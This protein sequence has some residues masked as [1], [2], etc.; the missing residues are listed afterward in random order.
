[1]CLVTGGLLLVS[2]CPQFYKQREVTIFLTFCY[3]N[4]DFYL[5]RLLKLLILRL[6]QISVDSFRSV[7]KFIS[8][9]W[10]ASFDA[11]DFVLTFAV[12]LTRSIS[13]ATNTYIIKPIW[14]FSNHGALVIW[15]SPYISFAASCFAISFAFFCHANNL[16]LWVKL[17]SIVEF[18]QSKVALHV[19]PRGFDMLLRIEWENWYHY[20]V[21]SCSNGIFASKSIVANGFPTENIWLI[22]VNQSLF[23]LS[24]LPSLGWTLY[25]VHLGGGAS[26]RALGGE[27]KVFIRGIMKAI[28]YPLIFSFVL[29]TVPFFRHFQCLTFSFGKFYTTYTVVSA[30][31]MMLEMNRLRNAPDVSV[32]NASRHRRHPYRQPYFANVATNALIENNRNRHVDHRRTTTSSSPSSQVADTKP[33]GYLKTM[34]P[35]STVFESTEC[36]ICMDDLLSGK[37]CTEKVLSG[38]RQHYHSDLTLP[39][40]HIYHADC[41]LDWL[42]E[43]PHCPSCRQVV[44]AHEVGV[45]STTNFIQDAFL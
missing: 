17:V 38:D 5:L 10:K 27:L 1:M 34:T 41:I 16:N 4:L 12:E 29:T 21:S 42:M 26:S 28:Y 8:V 44:P 31:V 22:T 13:N 9:V 11:L 30:V 36:P 23:K 24:E 6:N 35:P 39:C 19:L 43:Q 2:K 33:F 25:F 37:D 20:T 14:K 18:C 45:L 32:W 15:N 7:T 40:G 3:L